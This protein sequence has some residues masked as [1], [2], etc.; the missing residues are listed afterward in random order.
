MRFAIKSDFK[1]IPLGQFSWFSF[2]FIAFLF[3][4]EHYRW[5]PGIIAGMVYAGVLYR[6]KDL[7][8]S[9]LSHATTNLLLGI[10]VL[11]THHWSFW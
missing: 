2:I 11:A 3:G 8:E 1:S 10:Y 4:F 6:R 5:L 7:F 9:I